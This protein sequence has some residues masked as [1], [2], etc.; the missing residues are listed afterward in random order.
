[1]IATNTTV[2]RSGLKTSKSE[3]KAIGAGGLSGKPLTQK[4]LDIVKYLR[5]NMPQNMALIGVGGI[6]SHEDFQNMKDA[7]ADLIQIFTSFIYQG[8]SVVSKIARG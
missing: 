4:S 1:L 3:L 8:L 7:G 6:S 2:E 5:T